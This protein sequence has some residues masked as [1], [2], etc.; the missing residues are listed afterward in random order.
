MIKILSFLFLCTSLFASNHFT[1]S[2]IKKM[3]GKMVILGFNGHT[4]NKNETL[5]NDIKKYNLGGII[6][7]D[8]Y[9]KS[10]KKKNIK[11]PKQLKELITDIQNFSK[12]KMLIS[13]D[14][15]GGWVSRLNKNN[16][17]IQTPKASSVSKKN[18]TFAKNT[19]EKLAYELSSLGINLNFAPVV[20]LAINKKNKVIVYQGRSF[21]KDPNKVVKYSKVFIEEMNKKNV[22]SVIKHFPGHGSSLGDSHEG[23]VD[24]T[25]T[26][27]EKELK[28][29]KELINNN[30]A[31]IIMTAHVYNKNLDKN[32][33]ATLSYNINTKLLRKQMNF[34]GLVI[35]DDLQMNAISKHYSLKETLTLAINSGVNILLFGNH[36]NNK[37]I[38][39]KTIVDTIYEQ[40]LEDKIK[41]SKIIDSNKLIKEIL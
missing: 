38:K 21:S 19:Y 35:S 6:L 33:P 22:S 14:Q 32:Y 12:Y 4:F 20:D 36:I 2:E 41:L 8:K 9:Y 13:I 27:K 37:S 15:E 31:N 40:I 16:G 29:Y 23:F 39:L 26:W 1:Q 34:K 5:K 7:F 3:I 17:F 18:L 11:N 25:N 24:I 28:P 30:Y 10:K